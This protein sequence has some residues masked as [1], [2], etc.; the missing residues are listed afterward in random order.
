MKRTELIKSR[1]ELGYTQ[2]YVAKLLKG[3]SRPAYAMLESGKIKRVH[4]SIQR[5]L[6]KIYGKPI[7]VLFP[8]DYDIKEETI[9][10]TQEL[11]HLIMYLAPKQQKALYELLST[12]VK[13][14]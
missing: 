9:N 11:Q 10:Y 13:E 4:V 6:A 1:K 7:E 8:E 2:D 3:Y 5:Q 12:I 14:N